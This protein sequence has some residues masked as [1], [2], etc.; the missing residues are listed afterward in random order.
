MYYYNLYK[1]SNMKEYVC[2][3]PIDGY[4]RAV[5]LGKDISAGM[6]SIYIKSIPV[7]DWRTHDYQLRPGS[8]YYNY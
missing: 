6:G 1:L 5:R 7:E 2:C 3:S 8:K 4:E